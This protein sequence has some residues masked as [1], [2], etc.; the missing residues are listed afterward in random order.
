MTRKAIAAPVLVAALL[1]LSIF[2]AAGHAAA[3][4]PSWWDGLYGKNPTSGKSD[5]ASLY[6]WNPFYKKSL[7]ATGALTVT[8]VAFTCGD[9]STSTSAWRIQGNL[10]VKGSSGAWRLTQDHPVGKIVIS[11]SGILAN[12]SGT[13]AG[14]KK[15]TFLDG[16]ITVE[17]TTTTVN[18][19]PVAC[20]GTRKFH[21]GPRHR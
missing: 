19:M 9:G 17:G 21:I 1:L 4:G 5:G 12:K 14:K 11:A 15:S 2:A 8:K 6:D 13:F 18:G 10:V 16:T 3:K 20:T 7:P